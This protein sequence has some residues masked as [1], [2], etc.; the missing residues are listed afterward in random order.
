MS[1]T[2]D[3]DRDEG[4]SPENGRDAVSPT[5]AT[6][7]TPAAGDG[8]GEGNEDEVNPAETEQ[9]EEFREDLDAVERRIAGEIDPGV[10]AM[11]VAGAVFVLL[12]SLVLPHTGGA[13]G[14]D[15]LL[16]SEAATAEHIGL[17]SR[18]FVWF[19]LIFGIGFSLL[20]LM[21]RR[22]V[23]AWVAVAGSAI[24]SAFGVFS[25]WHR[26]T[27]GLNNYV[28]A[29]PGLGLVVGTLAVMVLTFHWVKVVWS[30]TAVQLAAEEQR[31][32]A[33]AREEERQR[34]ER[35]GKD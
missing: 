32:I 13:R 20:A 34:R 23:L 21:T 12:L 15:V 22:W 5:G 17:P 11:V 8:S 2:G 26:Q 24:A 33:A 31:R 28:G 10:R 7:G 29:G 6:P 19:V 18:I 27:P 16:G 25:I 14:F 30:R 1:A 4:R 35:F 9:F 3:D